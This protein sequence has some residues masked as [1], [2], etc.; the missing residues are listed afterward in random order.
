M[1]C[2]NEYDKAVNFYIE[3]HEKESD[4]LITSLVTSDN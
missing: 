2:T 3:I 4:Y 1:V